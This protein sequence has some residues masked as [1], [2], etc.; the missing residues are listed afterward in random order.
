MRNMKKTKKKDSMTPPK[1]S[2]STETDS[3]DSEEDEIPD[4]DF[5][6][7]YKNDQQIQRGQIST[8]L[9]QRECI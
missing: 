4:Q 7:N 1:V 6:K 8:T 3:N 2:N 9:I 5:K